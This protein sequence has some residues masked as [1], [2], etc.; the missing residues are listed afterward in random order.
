MT[1]D[2]A[3]AL[4]VDALGPNLT[5]IGRYCFELA[6]GL[7]ARLGSGNVHYFRGSHW[8]DDPLSLLDE[9]W[10]PKRT[11][12]WKRPLEAW[13]RRRLMANAIVHAPNYFL[14]EWADGGVAT[15]HDL[16]V[17]IYP[18]THPAERVKA[19]ER[20]FER[21]LG[22]AQ[23]LITDTEAVRQELIAMFALAPERVRVVSLGAPQ[24]RTTQ[25]LAWLSKAH[26]KGQGYILC[27]ST[28]EP[29]KRIDR[30]V[31]AFMTLPN[32]FR[33]QFPLVLAG[34]TG[35]RSDDLDRLI[36]DAS[37]DGSVRRLG[38]VSEEALQAL[39]AGAKLFVY[40]SRY[41]GF[42][43]PVVE[44]MAHGVPCLVADTTCLIEVAKGAARIIDPEDIPRF[45]AAIMETIE[46]LQWR[47]QAAGNGRRVSQSYTWD[48]CLDE[49]AAL[50]RT[51]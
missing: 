48:R 28:F 51:I 14:P 27:V 2:L 49:M 20:Q 50:Y 41:E 45:A 8:I 35:W 44:A 9:S 29:R 1:N 16:S 17:L 22:Q 18:E 11:P 21:T 34:A 31:R 15:I 13:T 19:F 5:G 24:I 39:Y 37:R 23:M 30:L 46:D 12:K 38:F 43:L 40:P 33:Q 47:A 10:R 7:P 36:E 4:S 25:D 6:R 42:G 32:A 26:L 3:V